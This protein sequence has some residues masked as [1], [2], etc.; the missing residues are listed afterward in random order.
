MVVLNMI[1]EIEDTKG[2]Y[3][4]AMHVEEFNEEI[5]GIKIVDKKG[6]ISIADIEFDDIFDSNEEKIRIQIEKSSAFRSSNHE[7]CKIPL[8]QELGAYLALKEHYLKGEY[9]YCSVM[10]NN[11]FGHVNYGKEF[12]YGKTHDEICLILYQTLLTS[13]EKN[14][15]INDNK[16]SFL[17]FVNNRIKDIRYNLR[18][19]DEEYKEKITQMAIEETIERSCDNEGEIYKLSCLDDIH[20]LLCDEFENEIEYNIFKRVLYEQDKKIIEEINEAVE[21]ELYNPNEEILR[22]YYRSRL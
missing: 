4:G 15:E 3:I 6:D 13:L 18:K 22:D 10:I 12:G 16:S 11:Y 9:Y 19:L 17:S 5:N 21:N 1:I 7:S 2:Y 14:S 8:E 20:D